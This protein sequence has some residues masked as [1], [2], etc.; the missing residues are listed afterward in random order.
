VKKTLFDNGTLLTQN[1]RPPGAGA[2][3]ARDGRIMAVGARADI[4]SIA[5]PGVERVDLD[6]GTLVPGFNA[7]R[8]R[9]YA[10][11]WGGS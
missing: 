9:V 10:K 8:A 4:A 11:R 2:L 3:L 1:P 7:S 5:G 6:G